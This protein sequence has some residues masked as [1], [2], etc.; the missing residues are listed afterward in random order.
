VVFAQQAGPPT[1]SDSSRDCQTIRRC[2]F[3]RTGSFR[4]CISAY[5]CRTCQLVTARCS[6]PGAT[7]SNRVCREMRCNWGA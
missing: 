1:A 4:G 6:I 2:N 5:S 3:T 7:S